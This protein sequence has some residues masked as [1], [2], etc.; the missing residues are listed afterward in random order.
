MKRTITKNYLVRRSFTIL[1]SLVMILSMMPAAFAGTDR[2]SA[3]QY[4]GEALNA[5][6]EQLQDPSNDPFRDTEAGSSVRIAEDYP[7]SYD[8]RDKGFV[9]PV[10]FQNPFGTCWG[11]AAIAAAE[12][13]ILGSGLAAKDGYDADTFDLS[14]KHLVYFVSQPIN[15]KND[16]QYGEGTQHAD[17]V[18]LADLLNG[19]G[20]PFTAT[21][22][23]AS[24]MGPVLEE[25]HPDLR[26][27][28]KNGETI[29]RVINGKITD[30]FYSDE[31]DWSLPSDWRY[32]QSYVLRES[33]IL[34]SP[35]QV[36]EETGEYTYNPVGTEEIK[37]MLMNNRAVQIGFHADQSTPGQE[38]DGKYISRH[39][40]HYTYDADAEGNHAVT[41]VGW[42]DN[43]DKSNFVEGHEPP[44]NGAWLVKNSWGSEERSFPH[45]GPAWGIE[46]S[47]GEHTGYFWLS[48]YDRTLA[49]P[50]ALDFDK[51]NVNNSYNIDEH[52]YMPVENVNGAAI[53]K[54]LVMAN[55]FK[56][57]ETQLLEQ[58]SCETTY[59]NTRVVNDIYILPDRFSDPTDGKLVDS[60]SDTFALGGFHKM[61]LKDPDIIQ[62]D[63]YYSIVQT[64]TVPNG[65][66]AINFPVSTSENTIKLLYPDAAT[67]VRGVVNKGESFLYADGRWIDYSDEKLREKILG[68]SSLMVT[69][70]NF[71]I[72]GY[73][74]PLANLNL[75]VAG[76]N[77]IGHSEDDN[78]SSFRVLFTGD[79][80][81]DYNAPA[82][83]WELAEGGSDIFTLTPDPADPT[84]AKVQ[85]KK[86]GRS[87]LFVTAEGIGT[88]VIPISVAKRTIAVTSI[89]QKDDTYTGKAKKPKVVVEDD[90][91][92][93]IPSSHYTVRYKNNIKCGEASAIVTIN[94]GDE[95][96]KHESVDA[97]FY[98][99]PQKAVI[100][101]LSTGKGRLTV[102]VKNQKKSGVVSYKLR[103]R[104]KGSKKWS[105]KTFKASKGT[106]LTVKG[107][108]KGKRYQVKV[109]AVGPDMLEGRYS[110]T[111][112]STAVR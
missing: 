4:D 50:E 67:W 77:V 63:Q 7:E 95:A 29:K 44:E 23:F 13:S 20:F 45:R 27:M 11:F 108:K 89:I 57:D 47:K 36:N 100:K 24:G 105:V 46:N 69:V 48:Y 37:Q 2:A 91:G 98:I 74:K 39:W 79:E 10:K 97:S 103:Y 90:T 35:A 72:K 86:Q 58:V 76:N 30:Y 64:Q 15:D 34:D 16:P 101:K 38:S 31:D 78:T 40:A 14:E 18:S 6:A 82:I 88:T 54:K 8:L 25:R 60:T 102:T 73:S 65:D 33:F 68:M 41:I 110:K 81:G 52:D 62:K 66:Y 49:M 9:T 84:R 109:C 107:L 17:G 104:A 42:D 85:S 43:Y 26:Y 96:Y 32:K 55:V 12:S 3:S 80:G 51:S 19:G 71:P 83:S 70:D 21:S 87:L 5:L 111:K 94:K 92:E 93:V 56:A 61:D 106:D 53:D 28:G 112:T 75:Y 22:L 99:V 1:L 59:A